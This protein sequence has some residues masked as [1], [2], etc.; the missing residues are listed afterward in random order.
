MIEKK[1]N[2]GDATQLK[3]TN[4]FLR[5]I[6]LAIREHFKN[7]NNASFSKLKNIPDLLS[8]DDKEGRLKENID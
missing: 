8:S 5:Y 4:A 1:G 2:F 6:S 3:I 7:I